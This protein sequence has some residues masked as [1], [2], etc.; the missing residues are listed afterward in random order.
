MH[1]S[2]EFILRASFQKGS[3]SMQREN[4]S[5]NDFWWLLHTLGRCRELFNHMPKKMDT[6]I[7]WFSRNIVALDCTCRSRVQTVVMQL[8]KHLAKALQSLQSCC[9]T[10]QYQLWIQNAQ[11]LTSFSLRLASN[12][13]FELDK[14]STWVAHK[15]GIYPKCIFSKGCF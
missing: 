5:L 9:Q 12:Q 11:R 8:L 2:P 1:T 13:I 10:I 4:C 15:S 7:T 14:T 3:F 6:P